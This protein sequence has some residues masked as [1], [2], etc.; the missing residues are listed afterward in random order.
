MGGISDEPLAGEYVLITD[1]ED[2]DEYSIGRRRQENW[3]LLIGAVTHIAH[4]QNFILAIGYDGY[5]IVRVREQQ[6]FGPM[7]AREFQEKRK[8]L[9]VPPGLHLKVLPPLD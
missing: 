3:T 9:Q 4:D 7:S 1:D 6:T 2:L 5:F 8:T